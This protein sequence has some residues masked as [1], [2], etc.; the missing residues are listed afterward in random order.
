M[1]QV[2]KRVD[3]L[4]RNKKI[5]RFI[6]VITTGFWLYFTFYFLEYQD[7]DIN[8]P[9]MTSQSLV[10]RVSWPVFVLSNQL[11]LDD[12]NLLETEFFFKNP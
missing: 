6:N 4:L 12:L 8:L 5:Y 9:P 2:F 1:L 10:P 7:Q 11:L 3:Q